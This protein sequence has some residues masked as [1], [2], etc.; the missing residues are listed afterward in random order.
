MINVIDQC[1]ESAL[2]DRGDPVR[3]VLRS[4]TLIIPD[5]TDDGDINFREDVSRSAEDDN[6]RENQQH[7]RHHNECVR[8]AKCECD[9]PHKELRYVNASDQ[10]NL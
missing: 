5:N 10:G 8:P 1:G 3:H 7:Q 6:G 4:E 9:N 2:G